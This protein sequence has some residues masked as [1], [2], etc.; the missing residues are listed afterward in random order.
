MANN[1]IPNKP[2]LSRRQFLKIV[3]IGGAAVTAGLTF[4]FRNELFQS[5]EAAVI[6]ETRLLMNGIADLTLLSDDPVKAREACEACIREMRRHVDIFNRFDPRSQLS[7]L[8]A[9]GKL[10]KP[11]P[12]LVTLLDQSAKI[13]QASAGAFDISIKPV[14]DLYL[15]AQAFNGELPAR[16]DIQEKLKLVDYKKI[17]YDINEIG[18][19][20]MG[21][22][23]TLDGIA[24]G[25]VVDAGAA[26][27]RAHG[28]ENVI[29]EAE[30]D[31]L[32]AGERDLQA[33]W[34]IG[35]RPPREGMSQLPVLQIKNQAVATSGD[36]MEAFSSDYSSYHILDPRRGFSSTELCSATVIAPT[37]SLADGLATAIMVLGVR[38]GLE[39]LKSFPGCEAF[40]IDKNLHS[41]HSPGMSMF[42]SDI[43]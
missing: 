32:A 3:A 26:S 42:T 37:A 20:S 19:S 18:F 5:K 7:Q 22:N 9:E 33:P 35:I 15:A 21:M 17:A 24:K 40:L 31:L 30:G 23:L 28:F 27:L 14:L 29:V 34:R 13:S 6:R 16:A 4:G 36:Y 39:L 10:K 8:N 25:A 12:M 38:D 1:Q 2:A 41:S 11:D 43:L